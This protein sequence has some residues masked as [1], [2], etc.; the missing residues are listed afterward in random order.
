MNI[1]LV[2]LGFKNG[3]IAFNK[4]QIINAIKNCHY[5]S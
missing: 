4:N 5:L 1:L 2:G 3:D